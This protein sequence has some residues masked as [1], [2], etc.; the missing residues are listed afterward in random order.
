ML[1]VCVLA[2]ATAVPASVGAQQ[3]L[4]TLTVTVADQSDRPI[5]DVELT[6]TWDGGS[7][8]E[9]TASN[10]Q[11]LVDVPKGADVTIRVSHPDYV[12]NDPYRVTDATGGPVDV[13]VW[14]KGS[15]VVDVTDGEGDVRGARVV[16]RHKRRVVKTGTTGSDGEYATGP[17][18]FGDYTLTVSKPGYYT[19]DGSIR[20]TG[21][22]RK[23]VTI[24]RGS[25]TVDFNVTDPHFDPPR[26]VGG[27]ELTLGGYGTVETLRNG[28]ASARL[29]VNT[30]LSVTAEKEGYRRVTRDFSVNESAKSVSLSMRRTPNL[31]LTPVNRRVVAGER[32]VVEVTN[33]Y[34]D[35]VAGVPVYRD[36]ARAGTTN[37]E[38][39]L[40]VRLDD[41]GNH[42]LYARSDDVRSESVTVRA[43]SAGTDTATPTAT[44]T[45]TPTATTTAD[46]SV[47]APGFTP[48]LA[49]L[50]LLVV[51][52]LF[53]RAT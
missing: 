5:A 24:E 16:V 35:P 22:T 23:P 43:I 51:A 13:P 28:E 7:T 47:P 2:G 36:D 18:Q 8:T 1:L 49:V 25:V 6:A 50:A 39:E 17:L 12:R 3:E 42:S 46:S 20:V 34:G 27:V 33:A 30:D 4:V 10:G 31:T 14:R 37:D 44:R 38:G 11:A 48:T 41:P 29:P 32:V 26:P 52:F 53:R 9:T 15:L 40:A 19:E 45:A 21:E